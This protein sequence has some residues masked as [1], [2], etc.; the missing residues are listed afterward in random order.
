MY[1]FVISFAVLIGLGVCVTAPAHAQGTKADYARAAALAGKTRG[2]VVGENIAPAWSR[3][4]RYVWFIEPRVGA[5]PQWM[6]IDTLSGSRAP[7]FDHEAVAEQFAALAERAV[8]PGQLSA[9]RILID[10]GGT[11]SMLMRVAG[12]M[13]VVKV[14]RDGNVSLHPLRDAGE[15]ALEA[16]PPGR[17]IRSTNLSDTSVHVTFINETSQS[18]ALHWINAQGQRQQYATIAP[19]ESHRQHTFAGHA[20]LATH[21]DSTTELAGYIAAPHGGVAIITGEVRPEPA[22]RDDN[23]G[24]R[25]NRRPG[26]NTSP[27]GKWQVVVRDANVFARDI[28]RDEQTQLTTFATEA[29]AFGGVCTGRPTV[30]SVL[31]CR[32]SRAAIGVCI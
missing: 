21:E 10:D 22:P 1:R 27:D 8:D 32:R 12:Q 2:K 20:W 6:V 23:R 3:D 18:V 17:R 30:A 16:R 5:P 11:V 4:G 31:S 25:N 15:L 24:Q 13:R 19:G 26:R 14:A 29:N 28:E 9:Q 7:A